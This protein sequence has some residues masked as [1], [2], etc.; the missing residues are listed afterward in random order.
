MLPTRGE[1]P[2]N[3]KEIAD[4]VKSEA[5][6][7]CVRCHHAHDVEAGYTLTVH[8]FDGDK[9]NCERW[10][11]MPL[12]QRCHLSVQSRVD[13]ETPLMFDPAAWSM[14]YIAGFY[15]AGRGMPSPLYDL[16]W[17]ITDYNETGYGM[18]IEWPKWAPTEQRRAA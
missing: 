12:C 4:L 14:P 9:A 10:N 1:Y 5:G 6:H 2:E 18:G 11:L 7:R 17:W 8:H 3:W 13:P 16:A 15:E